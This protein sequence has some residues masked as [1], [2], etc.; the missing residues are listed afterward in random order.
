MPVVVD[1]QCNN[2]FLSSPPCKRD[3][4]AMQAVATGFFVSLW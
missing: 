1:E 4:N 2:A 3:Y